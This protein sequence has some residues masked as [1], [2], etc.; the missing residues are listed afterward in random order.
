MANIMKAKEYYEAFL[1]DEKESGET[2]AFTNLI[3]GY[4]AEVKEITK[5]RMKGKMATNS[6]MISIF[7]E[8]N[9]KWNAMRKFDPRFRRD[10][11]LGFAKY[12]MPMLEDYL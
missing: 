7:K 10:G 6:V 1:R 12:R 11:F 5:I 3:N 2:Q 4:F 9:Q 8:Q